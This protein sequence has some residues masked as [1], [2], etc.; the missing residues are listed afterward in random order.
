MYLC[1]GM[2]YILQLPD[3]Q[4]LTFE[5]SQHRGGTQNYGRQANGQVFFLVDRN[6]TNTST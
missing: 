1:L 6:V 4:F 5:C 2:V 3:F